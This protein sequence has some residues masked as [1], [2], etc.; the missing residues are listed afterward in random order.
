MKDSVVSPPGDGSDSG[1]RRG[2][3]SVGRPI[4]VRD[5]PRS[6]LMHHSVA[7]FID[8]LKT[9]RQASVHTLRSYEDDLALY[10][11]YLAE[12]QGAAADPTAVDSIRLRRYSA[13]LTGRGYAAEHGGAS[14]GELALVFSLPSTGRPGHVGPVGRSPQPEAGQAVASSTPG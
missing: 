8:H 4:E 7:A 6:W 14:A 2:I 11:S 5:L 9:E 3:R 13:W 12:V 10:S 1:L